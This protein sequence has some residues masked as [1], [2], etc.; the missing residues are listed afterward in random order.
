MD[1]LSITTAVLRITTTCIVAAKE[2]NEIRNAWKRAPVT[3]SSL[4]SQ[5]KLTGAS[6]SQIQS[7]LLSDTDVL[8]EKPALIETL[9]TTLTSCLVLST[10]LEKYMLKIT[11]GVLDTSRLD[12][13]A[14]FKTLWNDDEV[15]ELQEQLHQQHAAISTLVGLLQ[16]D[17][18]TEMKKLIQKHGKMLQR[19]ANDTQRMREAHSIEAAESILGTDD[20]SSIFSKLPIRDDISDHH[21][22]SLFESEVLKS[23]VYS[24]A[25]NN[26]M[27][28]TADIEP[29]DA[30][31]V[32][33]D[34]M[35]M[36][37]DDSDC[38]IDSPITEEDS[39]SALMAG[40]PTFAPFSA[41]FTS[42]INY[43]RVGTIG[44]LSLENYTAQSPKE[45]SLKCYNDIVALRKLDEWRYL[46]KIYENDIQRTGIVDRRRLCVE[47][48][49]NVP[50]Q[51]KASRN[52]GSDTYRERGLHYLK[53]DALEIKASA[54]NLHDCNNSD[55]DSPLIIV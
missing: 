33:D 7:L 32:A 2:L 34:G 31:T 9:D 20:S 25:L 40:T 10:W 42:A 47:Y 13:K 21:S 8:Q 3:V 36:Y 48:R 54:R 4:C 39:A 12:W 53:G 6:L 41:S 26:T 16:M 23:N 51:I 35:T 45:L 27:K 38:T 19:I 29:D 15:K 49:L 44:A 18:L 30:N 5:L 28:Q 11:K 46:G 14:K 37:N 43:L 50:L 52:S 1:P 17:S 24:K 22:G 55:N